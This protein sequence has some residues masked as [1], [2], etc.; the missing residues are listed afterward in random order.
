MSLHHMLLCTACVSIE[1]P[2]NCRPGIKQLKFLP[3]VIHAV[4]DERRNRQNWRVSPS[5]GL[6]SGLLETHKDRRPTIC[7][8]LFSLNSCGLRDLHACCGTPLSSG[9]GSCISHPTH[10]G[11]ATL[12]DLILPYILQERHKMIAT[13]SKSSVCTPRV[14][15]GRAMRP[16]L[17]CRL[18]QMSCRNAVCGSG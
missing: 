1:R 7:F 2:E 15:N 11:R 4:L 10:L 17:F 9:R 3:N 8:A 16:R 5:F 18:W 13:E 6:V 14:S 12:Y